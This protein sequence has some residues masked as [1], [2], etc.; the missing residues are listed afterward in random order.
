MQAALLD[1]LRKLQDTLPPALQQLPPAQQCHNAASILQFY[2]TQLS[3]AVADPATCS[4]ALSSLQRIGNCVALLHL[5]SKQQAVQA[6]PV[7]MQAA[8]MLGIVGRPIQDAAA[9]AECFE[10][11]GLPPPPSCQAAA[12]AGMRSCAPGLLMPQI[13]QLEPTDSAQQAYE[14]QVKLPYPRC[15]SAVL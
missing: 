2:Q 10:L 6:T 12:L 4:S 1:Q 5:L 15:F 14:M 11:E 7:F 8:P 13:E 9:A 3:R